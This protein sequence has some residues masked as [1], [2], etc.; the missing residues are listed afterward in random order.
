MLKEIKKEF[1]K[2]LFDYLLFLTA[3]IVFIIALTIFQG[4]RTI[5]FAIVA[6]FIAFYISWGIYHHIIDNTLRLK[7]ILEYV[8]IGFTTLFLLKILIIP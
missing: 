3:C 1:K 6:A 7:V 2:N 5:E 4:E 8:L